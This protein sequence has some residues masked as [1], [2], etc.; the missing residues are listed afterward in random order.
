MHINPP[1]VALAIGAF[2]IGVTEFAPMV[3]CQASLR[4]SAYPFPPLACS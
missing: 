3:C 2:G 4:I 1:L